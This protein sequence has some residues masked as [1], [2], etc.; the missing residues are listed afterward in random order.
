MA[1]GLIKKVE[2]LVDYD[3]IRNKISEELS[4]SVNNPSS[5]L[6]VSTMLITNKVSTAIITELSE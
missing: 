4:D 3:E 2:E 5:T 1:R 6:T